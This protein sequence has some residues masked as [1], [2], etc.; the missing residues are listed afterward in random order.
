MLLAPMASWLVLCSVIGPRSLTGDADA[1]PPAAAAGSLELPLGA[2]SSVVQALPA[3]GALGLTLQAHA[4]DFVH[5]IVRATAPA[6]LRISAESGETLFQDELS[7]ETSELHYSAIR[8]RAGAVRVEL[9]LPK[10]DTPSTVQ[11]LSVG[12]RKA[13]PADPERVQADVRFAQGVKKAAGNTAAAVK[14]GLVDL[15]G[16][17]DTWVRLGDERE[18]WD[19]LLNIGFVLGNIGESAK[20]I[21]ALERCVALGRKLGDPHLLPEPLEVL[22]GE[23]VKKGDA[24]GALVLARES[25]EVRGKLGDREALALWSIANDLA[26]LDRFNEEVDALTLGLAKARAVNDQAMEAMLVGNRGSMLSRLGEWERAI[27]DL[28]QALA[29]DRLSSNRAH[30]GGMLHSLGVVQQRLGHV[31]LAEKLFAQ[32][33]ELLHDPPQ[34]ARLATAY[35]SLAG[36]QIEQG[37]LDLARKNVLE[38]QAAAGPK[39]PRKQLAVLKA[40]L[41][42]IEFAQGHTDASKA[43]VAELLPDTRELS[44]LS[45][46]LITLRTLARLELGFGEVQEALRLAQRVVELEEQERRQL[47]GEGVRAHFL[48]ARQRDYRV[49][50]DVLLE[51]NAREPGKGWDARALEGAERARARGLLDLIEEAQIDLR[52][53]VDPKLLEQEK[54]AALRLSRKGREL[55]KVRGKGKSDELTKVEAEY[56]AL[57]TEHEQLDVAIRAHSPRMA[58]L[59]QAEP[60]SLSELQ[61]QVLDKDTLLVEIALGESR[62]AVFVVGPQSLSTFALGKRTDLE[63]AARALH[64]AWSDPDKVGEAEVTRRGAALSKLLF[65]DAVKVLGKKRLVFVSEGALQFVPLG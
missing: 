36:A 48:A 44:Y 34:P 38:A 51:L 50:I 26:Y 7:W 17:L 63:A 35:S 62:G 1:A 53:G 12:P 18:Q 25:A 8:D 60:L 64:E 15:Q 43:L 9:R 3:T 28:E 27:P 19:A 37:K 65:G 57:S 21:E 2:D 39:G 54:E 5:L 11:V 45:W 29:W 23:L 33:V 49:L 58:A 42:S 16:A 55:A 46:E 14:E 41:A 13:L 32:E 30:E 61:Q 59:T 22:G 6:S 40:Q 4:G 56:A 10:G 47:L 24:Q 52:A 31:D 20:S